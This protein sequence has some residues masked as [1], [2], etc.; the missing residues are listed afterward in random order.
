MYDAATELYNKHFERYYD[1][2]QKLLD[3][4]QNNLKQKFNPI[5]L[6]LED[7][8]NDGCILEEKSDDKTIGD[9]KGELDYL[10]PLAGDEE[11]VIRKEIKIYLQAN[12]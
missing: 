3:A 12:Y 6:K 2:Y 10:T 8:D 4:T 9:R 5:N 1:D 7:Y 11:E